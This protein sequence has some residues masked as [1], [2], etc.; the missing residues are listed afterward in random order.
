[1]LN[2][3]H[4]HFPIVF[5]VK[6]MGLFYYIFLPNLIVSDLFPDQTLFTKKWPFTE[7]RCI[8]TIFLDK[9]AGYLYYFAKR[10]YQKQVIT[11]SISLEA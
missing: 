9:R 1:M 4:F 2:A 7:N 8:N 5:V 3:V 6:R 10:T 11:T